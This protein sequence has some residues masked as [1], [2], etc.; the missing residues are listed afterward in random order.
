MCPLPLN[1]KHWQKQDLSQ[2]CHHSCEIVNFPGHVA[3]PV[4]TL[5][6]QQSFLSICT[7]MCVYLHIYELHMIPTPCFTVHCVIFRSLEGSR[8][9]RGVERKSKGGE[10]KHVLRALFCLILYQLSSLGPSEK[11]NHKRAQSL[12][13]ILF[14]PCL[15]TLYYSPDTYNFS[16]PCIYTVT[17]ASH[18]W[19]CG[20][21]LALCVWLT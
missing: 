20:F 21:I 3:W 10:E 11:L 2:R 7:S 1:E 14:S 19:E 6:V 15:N 5:S 9:M 12:G 18:S 4:C 16:S 17:L 8:V 13:D